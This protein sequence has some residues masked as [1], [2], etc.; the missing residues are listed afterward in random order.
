MNFE[1]SPLMNL[2]L[3]LIYRGKAFPLALTSPETSKAG[4]PACFQRTPF[5]RG[6]PATPRT[7]MNFVQIGQSFK[8]SIF[9]KGCAPAHAIHSP[10]FRTTPTAPL[11][12]AG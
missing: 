6:Y 10:T 2:F 5:Q 3:Y 9:S 11:V 7:L 8:T 1:L 12:Q 4:F